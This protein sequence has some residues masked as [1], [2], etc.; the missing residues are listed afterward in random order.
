[1]VIVDVYQEVRRSQYLRMKTETTRLCKEAS[2]VVSPDQPRARAQQTR[3]N[4]ESLRD[5]NRFRRCV[6]TRRVHLLN[7]TTQISVPFYYRRVT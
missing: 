5:M 1:M 2:E 7:Y 3:E 4:L 6:H